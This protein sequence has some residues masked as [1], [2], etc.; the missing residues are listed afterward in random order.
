MRKLAALTV[1]ACLSAFAAAPRPEV[2]VVTTDHVDLP[3]DAVIHIEN[4][5]GELNIEAWDEPQAEI[6]VTRYTFPDHDTA[7][8]RED[9][10]RRLNALQIAS[11]KTG[12]KDLTIST[13]V[14]KIWSRV[15]IDYRIRVPRSSSLVIHHR[16]GD[17]QIGGVEGDIDATMRAGDIL[18]RLPGA[19]TYSFNA[20][21]GEGRVVSDFPGTY[22]RSHLTGEKFSGSPNSSARRHN[23]HVGV[24]GIGIQQ[25]PSS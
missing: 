23:L 15:R 20:S 25:V 4:S 13:P 12:D 24:A 17:V 21:C 6:T 8:A 1:I 5:S 3:P 10:A 9:A 22:S 19:G 14:Q 11:T 16:T 7:S 18:L 2:S